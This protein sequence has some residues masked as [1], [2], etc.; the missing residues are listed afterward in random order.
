[1]EDETYQANIFVDV[2]FSASKEN[3]KAMGSLVDAAKEAVSAPD[4]FTGDELKA[5][6]VMALLFEDGL[7]VKGDD[8]FTRLALLT[9]EITAI[10][11]HARTYN[12]PRK[13]DSMVYAA[14]GQAY[15][16]EG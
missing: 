13:P 6:K 12:A 5:G 8:A 7:D 4:M 11:E 14:M 15:R 10:A 2:P 3:T 1:M 9:K 16:K